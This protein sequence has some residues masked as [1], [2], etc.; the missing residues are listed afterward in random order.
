MYVR[1]FN[2]TDPRDWTVTQVQQWLEWAINEF[3]LEGVSTQEFSISGQQLVDLGR[4]NFLVRAPPYVGDIL[5]EHL[6]ILLK[7]IL[8]LS[9]K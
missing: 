6:D 1:M 7:G 3:H 4:D 2:A 5:W 9:P 8:N